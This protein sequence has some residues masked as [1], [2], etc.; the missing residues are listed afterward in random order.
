MN[1]NGKNIPKTALT[2]YSMLLTFPSTQI[3]N[4]HSSSAPW[5]S[6][7]KPMAA[8]SSGHQN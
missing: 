5:T 8:P 2:T 7:A 3:T 6:G 1:L 4:S